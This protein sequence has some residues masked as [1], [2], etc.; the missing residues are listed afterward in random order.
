L[1][2]VSGNYTLVTDEKELIYAFEEIQKHLLVGVDLENDNSHSYE[3]Y[4][5]LVQISVYLFD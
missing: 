2:Y 4:L 3:G 1:A 5:C